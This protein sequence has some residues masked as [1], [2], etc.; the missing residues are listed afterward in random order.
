[1]YVDTTSSSVELALW[2]AAALIALRS[3]FGGRSHR[4]GVP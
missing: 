3:L 4:E 2:P 1:V